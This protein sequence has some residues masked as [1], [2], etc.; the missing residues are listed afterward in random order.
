MGRSRLSRQTQGA[1]APADWLAAAYPDKDQ[2]G[3]PVAERG[4]MIRSIGLA[5]AEFSLT[6]KSAVYNLKRMA[7]LL[8]TA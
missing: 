3:R 2:A 5:R 8:E 4:K 6:L 1:L 7:S